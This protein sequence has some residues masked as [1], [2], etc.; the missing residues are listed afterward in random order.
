MTEHQELSIWIVVFEVI[1]D[2]DPELMPDGI[3][4]VSFD[5]A[6]LA[7]KLNESGW[8][9]QEADT[10]IK[11]IERGRRYAHIQLFTVLDEQNYHGLQSMGG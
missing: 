4:H 8:I 2:D 9:W 6:L 5:R 1:T 11:D 3:G 10:Y 7:R